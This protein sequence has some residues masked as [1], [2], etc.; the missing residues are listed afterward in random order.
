LE[1]L[2]AKDIGRP[3]AFIAK[4]VSSKTLAIELLKDGLLGPS[5]IE[6]MLD[7][8]SPKEV[9]LDLLMIISDLARMSKVRTLLN[10]TPVKCCSLC[11]LIIFKQVL[12]DK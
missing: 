6:K 5:T 12:V 4:M 7:S 10:M 1:H 8:A 3:V 2:E 11:F 9:T